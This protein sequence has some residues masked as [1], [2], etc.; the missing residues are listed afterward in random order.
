[1]SYITVDNLNIINAE[2]TNW[3]NASCPRCGR[4]TW[5]ELKLRK[6]RVNSTHTS[7]ELIKNGLG[8]KIISQL[9]LNIPT[10]HKDN[11]PKELLSIK[12]IKPGSRNL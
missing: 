4:F 2:M 5:N 11:L 12:P 6:D 1:M 3:C 10:Y 8:P 7:L 9:E